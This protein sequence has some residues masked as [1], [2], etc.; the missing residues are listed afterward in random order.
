MSTIKYKK[1]ASI[2]PNS[3]M[4]FPDAMKEVLGVENGDKVVFLIDEDWN[5]TVVGKKT[6]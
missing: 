6:E 2:T 3:K 5:V 1:E 4:H